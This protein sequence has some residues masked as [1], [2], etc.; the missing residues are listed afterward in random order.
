MSNEIT[1][2]VLE[3]QPTAV[4][5][6]KVPIE[7]I[8]EWLSAAYQEISARLSDLGTAAVGPPFASYTV[9]DKVFEVEA[10]FPVAAEIPAQERVEPSMLSGGTAAVTTYY[11]PYDAIASAYQ[12]LDEWL[13]KNGYRD[14]GMRWEVYYTDPVREPDPAHWRTDVVAPYREW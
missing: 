5:R 14:N 9:H 13:V 12:A 8:S 7:N 2:R 6:D 3:P 11:G 4:I 10:G 1:S